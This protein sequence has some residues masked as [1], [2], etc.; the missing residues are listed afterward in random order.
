MLSCLQTT[1]QQSGLGCAVLC[2]TCICIRALAGRTARAALPWLPCAS[3]FAD[4]R[5]AG[6][7]SSSL[8]AALGW[9]PRGPRSPGAL[10]CLR[11]CTHGLPPLLLWHVLGLHIEQHIRL[12]APAAAL[13]HHRVPVA[14]LGHLQRHKTVDMCEMCLSQHDRCVSNPTGKQAYT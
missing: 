1:A 13:A 6:N 9:K 7:S 8:K 3:K 14:F 4:R 11:C 5:A 12:D 10:Q 2:C